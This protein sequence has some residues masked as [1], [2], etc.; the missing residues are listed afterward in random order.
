METLVDV[1]TN[2]LIAEATS[3]RE[4]IITKYNAIAMW[5]PETST[6]RSPENTFIVKTESNKDLIDWESKYNNPINIEAFD[7]YFEKAK[8]M[9][10]ESRK[11][12]ITNRSTCFNDK[13]GVNISTITN[14]AITS[15]FTYNMFLPHNKNINKKF[16]LLVIPKADEI[17]IGMDFD[18]LKGII[19]GSAYL[20]S[21]KKLMFTVMNY[22]LPQSKVLPLHCSANIKNGDTT[23]FLGLSGTGKTTLSIDSDATLIGDDEHGWDEDGIFNLEYGCYAKLYNISKHRKSEIYN[24]IIKNR[25]FFN[26]DVILENVMVYP[27]GNVDFTDTRLTQNS[28][29]SFPL[30]YVNNRQKNGKA[31]HPKTIIFLTADA[32]GVLPPISKLTPE[33]AKLW[34]FMGYTSK[35]I[36]TETKIENPEPIF[37]KFFGEPFMPCK[38]EI[39]YNLFVDKIVEHETDVFLVNTGWCNEGLQRI[40][41]ETTQNI[42]STIIENN[43]DDIEYKIDPIFKL[44]TPKAFPKIDNKILSPRKAWKSTK[45]YYNKAKELNTK[46]QNFFKANQI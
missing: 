18:R 30:S 10:K 45:A 22:L 37:S 25:P 20:G 21:V 43:L 14:S 34:F 12:Y 1:G 8:N 7:K 46:F 41:L 6:G 33:Q 24:I 2:A 3:N 40:P 36:G 44:K 15:L 39:Y 29:S 4:A 38:P 32:N 19:L 9:L 31:P 35:A 26:N 28:R 23:L 5:S 42:I 16:E 13:Y 27:D 17:F 11:N